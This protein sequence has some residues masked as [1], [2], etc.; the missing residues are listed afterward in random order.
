MILKEL[1]VKEKWARAYIKFEYLCT[2]TKMKLCWRHLW[3]G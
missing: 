2:Q 1:E 3:G